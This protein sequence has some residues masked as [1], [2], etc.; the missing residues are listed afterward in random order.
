MS[1]LSAHPNRPP[2]RIVNPTGKNFVE[3]RAHPHKPAVLRASSRWYASACR[4][5]S[6]RDKHRKSLAIP[7]VLLRALR[8]FG[9]LVGWCAAATV[10]LL[11]AG[12]GGGSPGAA[13]TG[14]F[15]TTTV[16]ID[17]AQQYQRIAGFGV[18]E[19]FGQGRTL[20]RA[21]VSNVSRAGA[22]GL[23][24]GVEVCGAWPFIIGVSDPP[25]RC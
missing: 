23:E 25:W 18:S 1:N 24:G 6:D 20:M 16:T 3:K 13:R 8:R 19:G 10:P 14:A 11:A 9:R 4:D 17:A 5:G 15:S 2:A 22:R 7:E 21:P 12:C